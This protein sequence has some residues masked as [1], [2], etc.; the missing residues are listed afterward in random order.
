[1]KYLYVHLCTFV[2]MLIQ[3]NFLKVKFQGQKLN[4]LHTLVHFEKF[5]LKFPRTES[6]SVRL[7]APLKVKIVNNPGGL[8]L[9][10]PS[11][12]VT[13]APGPKVSNGLTFLVWNMY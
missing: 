2:E 8:L 11:S 3:D 4:H 12:H 6:S 10:V 9:S 5:P 1:M 7:G 13:Y